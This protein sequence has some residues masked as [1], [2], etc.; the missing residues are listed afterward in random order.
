MAIDKSQS[1]ADLPTSAKE[2]PGREGVNKNV[3]HARVSK[4]PFYTHMHRHSRTIDFTFGG[5]TR[6]FL[7]DKRHAEMLW[8]SWYLEQERAQ[9]GFREQHEAGFTIW[10][11]GGG[12]RRRWW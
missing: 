7:R 11:D 10:L 5:S 2:K 4:I 12:G 9:E 3:R 1:T 8:K 6:L